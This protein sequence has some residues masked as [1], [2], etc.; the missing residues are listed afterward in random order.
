MHTLAPRDVAGGLVRHL[1]GDWGDVC[2][3]DRKEN[4][5]SL[6]EGFRLLSVYRDTDGT[7]FWIITEADRSATTVLLPEDHA[8]LIQLNYDYRVPFGFDPPFGFSY[9][10][11]VGPSPGIPA[12]G[13]ESAIALGL[14]LLGTAVLLIRRARAR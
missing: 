7:K 12:L 8:Y 11:T 6:K 14:L 5:F 13:M 4:E 1:S 3:Q 10:I 9:A 2:E